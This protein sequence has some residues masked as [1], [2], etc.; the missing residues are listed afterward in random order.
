MNKNHVTTMSQNG[1]HDRLNPWYNKNR[2]IRMP[3]YPPVGLQ[4]GLMWMN[5]TRMRRTRFQQLWRDAFVKYNTEFYLHDQDI[6]NAAFG[7]K[8]EMVKM[9]TTCDWHYWLAYCLSEAYCT[10]RKVYVLHG[11]N[12]SF[13]WKSCYPFSTVW[14]AFEKFSLDQDIGSHLLE[15]LLKALGNQTKEDQNKNCGKCINTP[16]E[17]LVGGLRTLI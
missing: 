11:I 7:A 16:T 5:L 14:D 15:P 1:P 3:F 8:P 10:P 13:H 9:L 2:Y 6:L 4:S 17:A 12:S